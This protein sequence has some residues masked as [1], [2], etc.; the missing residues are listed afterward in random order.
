MVRKSIRQGGSY[1]GEDNSSG[2]FR[3]SLIMHIKII[4]FQ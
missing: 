4:V 2:A 1:Q 3:L